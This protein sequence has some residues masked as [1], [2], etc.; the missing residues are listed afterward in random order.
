MLHKSYEDY[1][2][3]WD[4][5]KGLLGLNLVLFKFAYYLGPALHSDSLTLVRRA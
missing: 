2:Q 5:F 1:R 4:L 3:A